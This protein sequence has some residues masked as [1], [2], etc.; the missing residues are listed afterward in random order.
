VPL[1]TIVI[2]AATFHEEA[3]TVNRLAGLLI[4]FVGVVVLVSRGLSGGLAGSSLAGELALIGSS[5]CYALGNVYSRRAVR[6]LRPMVPAFFQVFFALLITGTLAILL[7]RPWTLSPT[8]EALVAVVWLGIVGSSLAYLVYFRLL[9][10]WGPTRTS[11]VAYL[12]PVVGI[13][14]GSIVLQETVDARILLGTALVIGG[15][16]LVNSRRGRRR[17]LGRAIPIPEAA[18]VEPDVLA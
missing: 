15:V 13:V 5:M 6:G 7:E 12:L 4:G 8:P 10:A 3:I 14:L 1:F 2:A 11:M 16:A 18:P 17:L 9:R